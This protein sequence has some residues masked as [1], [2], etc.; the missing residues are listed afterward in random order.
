MSYEVIRSVCIVTWVRHRSKYCR[1]LDIYVFERN[2]GRYYYEYIQMGSTKITHRRGLMTFVLIFLLCCLLNYHT[3]I[4]FMPTL[5]KTENFS[6]FMATSLN[7]LR[8]ATVL[9]AIKNI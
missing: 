1:I 3:F 6:T 5:N 8:L 2:R 4:I 9:T 7:L